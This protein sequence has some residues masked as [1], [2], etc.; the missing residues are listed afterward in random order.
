MAKFILTAAASE[1]CRG[2]SPAQTCAFVMSDRT[3]S[4]LVTEVHICFETAKR[5]ARV[6]GSCCRIGRLMGDRELGTFHADTI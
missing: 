2:F 3:K 4:A 1:S 6:Y 5:H